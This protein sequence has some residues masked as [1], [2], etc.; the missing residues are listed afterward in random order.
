ARRNAPSVIIFD[1]FDAIASQRTE[2]P[3][4]GS[5][6]GNAVV[7]QLLTELDG[8]REDDSILVVA[9]TNRID[10]I[11][12]A[13][14][15]PSRFRPIEVPLPDPE[16]RIAICKI[17]AAAYEIDTMLPTGAIQLV[18]EYSDRLNGDELRAIFQEAASARFLHGKPFT[19]E[20]LGELVGRA[21]ER[22]DQHTRRHLTDRRQ[23][24]AEAAASQSTDNDEQSNL[25][26]D[27]DGNT[28]SE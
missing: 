8:F 14:L 11:D 26:G 7:A 9:T 6:A 10:I 3:D 20:L 21:R 15:R 23:R 19:I 12:E 28:G 25:T 5:R 2:G 1:E 22:R 13:L 16:A 4:G 17:H 18:A 24:A 27:S